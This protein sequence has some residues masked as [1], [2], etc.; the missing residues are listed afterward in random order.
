MH[1]REFERLKIKRYG[2]RLSPRVYMGDEGSGRLAPG[3]F[4]FNVKWE[5]WS[6]IYLNLS[7]K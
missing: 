2:Q 7:Q 1:S 5:K 4:Q 6:A 3:L